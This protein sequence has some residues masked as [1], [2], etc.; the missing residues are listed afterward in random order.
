MY[1]IEVK[2][3]SFSYE[4]FNVLNNFSEDFN[5]G[6]VYVIMGRSGCGMTTLLKIIA[7]LIYYESGSILIGGEN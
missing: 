5:P 4:N 1:K 3:L 2:N 7:G 6:E